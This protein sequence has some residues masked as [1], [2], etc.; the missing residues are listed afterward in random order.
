M[1]NLPFMCLIRYLSGKTWWIVSNAHNVGS[2]SDV[3]AKDHFEIHKTLGGHLC[4]TVHEVVGSMW[5]MFCQRASVGMWWS[6]TFHF[7][8]DW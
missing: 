6:I 7:H 8:S 4:E 5:G 3:K 2:L 1:L